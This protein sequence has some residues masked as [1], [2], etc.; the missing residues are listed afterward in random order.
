MCVWL[1]W[2]EKTCPQTLTSPPTFTPSL[3]LKFI[4]LLRFPPLIS[5]TSTPKTLFYIHIHTYIILTQKR[6]FSR[7]G[8]ELNFH[9]Q[10][11]YVYTCTYVNRS[12]E[13][14][15]RE[16]FEEANNQPLPHEQSLHGRDS[17]FIYIWTKWNRQNLAFKYM[18]VMH[19]NICTCPFT[20]YYGYL[21][22]MYGV[23]KFTH[24]IYQLHQQNLI[25]H[26]IK[27]YYLN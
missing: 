22:N 19:S 4:S 7:D 11:I 6:K 26:L 2:G 24:F 20:I 13:F 15:R 18:H 27:I 8:K 16:L 23:K 17:L 14:I 9:K 21:P 1:K 5:S 3:Q 12:H 25:T 10:I